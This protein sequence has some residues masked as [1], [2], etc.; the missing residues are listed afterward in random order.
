MDPDQTDQGSHI[1][2]LREKMVLVFVLRVHSHRLL[3]HFVCK[4]KEKEKKLDR[5]NM[6]KT[7]SKD[8]KL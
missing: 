4:K 2:C 8:K 3:L 7:D 6:F 5:N 1:V